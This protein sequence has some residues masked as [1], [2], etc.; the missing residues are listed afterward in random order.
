MRSV[1]IKKIA[2]EFCKSNLHKICFF[3]LEEGGNNFRYLIAHFLRPMHPINIYC[4][5]ILIINAVNRRVK[6]FYIFCLDSRRINEK[7]L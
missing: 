1:F 5:F 2:G 7:F 6:Y 3:L 4:N